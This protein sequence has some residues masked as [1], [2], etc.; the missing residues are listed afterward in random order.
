[1]FSLHKEKLADVILSP[2]AA[3]HNML[4]G[5]LP[6]P[7]LLLSPC[8]V[9]VDCEFIYPGYAKWSRWPSCAPAVV[10]SLPAC[11]YCRPVSLH[12]PAKGEAACVFVSLQRGLFFS[13]I[14]FISLPGDSSSL[15]GSQNIMIL[16][17][18]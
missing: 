7:L 14:W 16:Q 8:C 6:C 2:G 3:G 4:Q 17:I 5:R 10:S 15:I 18:V 1:M 9:A 11:C 12:A 13:G